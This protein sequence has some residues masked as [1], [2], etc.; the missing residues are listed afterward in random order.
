MNGFELAKATLMYGGSQY[1]SNTGGT[2]STNES[3]LLK[4]A[5]N[6]DKFPYSVT[7]ED[8]INGSMI[9]MHVPIVPVSNIAIYQRLLQPPRQLH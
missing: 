4:L 3:L 8:A 2:T 1:E 9:I 7:P 6:I 5:N